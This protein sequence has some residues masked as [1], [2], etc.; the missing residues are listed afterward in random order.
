[1]KNRGCVPKSTIVR[2]SI[3][4]V[5]FG[6]LA[7]C[8]TSRAPEASGG[9]LGAGGAVAGTTA[10]ASSGASGGGDTLAGGTA[11]TGGGAASGG[12]PK[13]EAS[14]AATSAGANSGSSSGGRIA[15]GGVAGANGGS[16]QG[17]ANGG[18]SSAGATSAGGGGSA[19][20][21]S[22][23]PGGTGGATAGTGGSAGSPHSGVWRIM[24][25]GD[26][27]TQSTCYPQLLS[28]KLRS[29]G[30][31]N[32]EFLGSTT[33]NQSCSGAPNVKTEGHGGYLVTCVT[34][35]RTT[36]CAS[37]GSPAELDAWLSAKPAPDVVLMHYG[38]N[39]A[40]TSD[41][42]IAT[43]TGAYTKI[44]TKLRAANPNVIIFAAQILPMHPDN[45]VDSNA[46]CP[47]VRVKQLN[48]AIPDWATLASTASSPIYVVDIY[49]SVGNADNFK[50][51]SADT[52]DGV[53][54]NPSGSA[55]M[56]SVWD[57]AL[58]ARAIPL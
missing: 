6:T 49:S 54:P 44:V 47:N 52:A 8:G 42:P 14:G 51:N 55:K 46:S 43:I 27:I 17:G 39:D 31:T 20:S 50:P 22:T 21:S 18:A 19:G 23:G 40:W 56:V 32:F 9:S 11:G 34:G 2:W 58:G 33:N 30:H 25:L 38:T 24:P 7:A 1:M 16:S 4:W 37:K 12:S 53:H 5:L 10:G 29:D 45:C 57:A 26:S 15:T 36:G 48:A 13:G 28:Q 41:I 35:D 3:Q